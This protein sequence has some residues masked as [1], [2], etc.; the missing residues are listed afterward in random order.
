MVINTQSIKNKEDILPNYLRSE[1]ID[2]VIATE[3]W[4]TNQDRDVIQMEA[5]ELVKDVYL[6]SAINRDG[7]RGRG[8]ALL[9]RSNITVS[10][11]NQKL[12]RSFE[13][14][15]R[16]SSKG[17]STLNLKSIYHPPYP[18]NQRIT[19]SMFLDDLTDHLT[20]WMASVRNIVIC[21][22][23]NIHINDINDPEA[24][25]FKDTMEAVGLQQHVCFTTH[26]TGNTL[27]LIFTKLT[28]QLNTKI[29]KGRYILDHRAIVAELDIRIQHTISTMVTF[30]NL[31]QINMEEL[32]SSIDF[33]S[34][35][36]WENPTLAS[37]K[38]EKELTRV[39]DQFAPQNT[40]LIIKRD[41]RSWFN[42]VANMKRAL[43]RCEKSG[44][45]MEL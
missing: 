40:K 20:E 42:E 25:I 28:P 3:T 27:D 34:V 8:L 19:N 45:E 16:M 12:Y 5:N 2:M 13:V 38:Y 29:S 21:R 1:A 9:Y 11:I 7:K 36:N 41:K 37:E 31:R 4:L 26:P 33:G 32:I 44:L 24:Q 18:V 15:H 30:R 22:D 14:A 35:E 39:L 17:N 23:F 10:K 43:R 6:I